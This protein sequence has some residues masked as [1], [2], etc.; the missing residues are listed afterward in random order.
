MLASKQ[1]WMILN[2]NP[3][4]CSASMEGQSAEKV[5]SKIL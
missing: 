2:Y 4:L 1:M 3:V 5:L